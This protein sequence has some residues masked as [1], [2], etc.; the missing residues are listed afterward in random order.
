MFDDLP[1]KKKTS[2][3]PRDLENMSVTEIEEYISEMKDEI[4][5]AESDINKKQASMNAADSFFK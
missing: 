4:A 3:F 1:Q 2:E 5:R